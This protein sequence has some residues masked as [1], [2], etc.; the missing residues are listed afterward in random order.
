MS[1]LFIF[2][3]TLLKVLIIV[4]PLFLF[5]AYFTY[6]ER[7]IIGFM[8]LRI[9]PHRVGPYGLLQ[10]FADAFKLLFKEIIIPTKA[11]KFLFF[12]APVLAL[13]PSLTAWSVIPFSDGLLL[14]KLNVGV[15]FIFTMT[16]LS[17]YGIILAGWASNSKYA[18]FGAMRSIAQT[19]SYEVVMGFTLVGV[20]LIAGSMELTNIVLTQ[21]GGFLKWHFIPLFPLFMV[22]W[23]ASFAETNRAPFDVA[24]GESEIVAGFHLDYSGMGFTVF[25]LA[26]YANMLLVSVVISLLFCGGWLSPFEGIEVLDMFFYY[27]PP[28]GWLIM[29]TLFFTFSLLWIRATFPRYRYDQIMRLCWRILMPVTI[30]WL[31]IL[32]L[33]FLLLV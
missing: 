23:I 9:G 14:T 17:V 8:Q 19:I 12:L 26:E 15:L 32:V 1:S 13:V 6:A 4:I 3:Y 33:V 27:I 7:K 16:S 18:L 31:L 28:I 25:F 5:V 20:V 2:L 29:K 21:R 24:E 30:V 10:P 22:F 11:D